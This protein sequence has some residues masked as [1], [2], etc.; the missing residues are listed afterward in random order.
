MKNYGKA[1][2]IIILICTANPVFSQ[3][4][5]EQ[6]QVNTER[7]TDNIAISLPF[8]STLGN[9]WSDAYIG[10]LGDKHF[11]FGVG[12]SAGFTNVNYKAVN[13]M[14]KCF[15]FTLPFADIDRLT[16][17]GLLIPAYTLDI[18][19]GGFNFPV[20]FGIK[21]SY[22]PPTV[23]GKIIKE[24]YFDFKQILFGMDARYS[25]IN[26]KLIPVRF[27][28]G[29]GINFMDGGIGADLARSTRFSFIYKSADYIIAPTHAEAFLQWRTL[30]SEIKTQ[31]SFPFRF[32]TP[33]AGAGA[34]FAWT[35]TGY[36]ISST[37]L[38]ISRDGAN[39]NISDVTNVLLD[40]YGL[41][42][43][44]NNGFET[45][46]SFTS[47]SARVFGGFSINIVYIR[48]DITGMYEI[49]SGNFG[50]TIGLRFQY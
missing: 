50:G 44:S 26:N 8:H 1:M 19:A 46:K 10:Q 18:R 16:E 38:N 15:R 28:A 22:I 21:A 14:M 24:F 40:T 11:R 29:I 9:N 7:F 37:G 42:G 32:L 6:M 3:Y 4:S 43:I 45:I 30:N 12:L 13:D 2:L 33:Y 47:I 34:I 25:F 31:I 20:D 5:L 27:S 49:F 41:T 17:I 35:Q 23:T 36:V 48:I 39:V